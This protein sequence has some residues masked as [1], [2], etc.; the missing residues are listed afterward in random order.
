MKNLFSK[1]GIIILGAI[2]VAGFLIIKP[3]NPVYE[4]PKA[5]AA[6]TCAGAD[7]M[8]VL[9][10]SN[11]MD[12]T[13]I[14]DAKSAARKFAEIALSQ[15]LKNRV[16]V[17]WFDSS[18]PEE[19][20]QDL[21]SVLSQV[22][23]A[24]DS[25]NASGGT[26]IHEGMKRARKHL[27]ADNIE[28]ST[29]IMVILTDGVSDKNLADE[30]AN[31]FDG[32]TKEIFS[33]LLTS[34]LKPGDL[35]KAREL[36]RSIA[37]HP[38]PAHYFESPQ[39]EDL[40][41]IFSSIAEG[42]PT[43]DRDGDGFITAECKDLCEASGGCD[44]DDNNKCIAP[45]AP[46]GRCVVSA[47]ACA[48]LWSATSTKAAYEKALKEC[49]DFG[50]DICRLYKE[51]N[52]SDF[53]TDPKCGYEEN[54]AGSG[55]Y[56]AGCSD[57]FDNNQNGNVDTAELTCPKPGG[58][59]VC[60]RYA[61]DPTT[62]GID[63]SEPCGFC[64][65]FSLF[66]RIIDW[67]VLKIAPTIAALLLIIGGLAVATSRGNQ[68][69]LTRGKDTIIWTLAGYAVILVGWML[70][71]SFFGGI[72]V[73]TWTGIG[74]ESGTITGI[75]RAADKSGDTLF[76]KEAAW[77]DDEFNG[78]LITI[79]KDPNHPELEGQSR[80]ILDTFKD[81]VGGRLHTE[82]WGDVVAPDGDE[83]FRIGGDWWQ[84]TCGTE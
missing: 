46:E 33:V 40:K 74:G 7:I 71:N 70:V 47:E 53:Y 45:R 3:Q 9:D 11:S 54:P 82:Y 64:H 4:V 57:G 68:A 1:S 12:G 42:L 15:Q 2:L 65:F 63:E 25:G 20:A 41:N 31:A 58:L 16:G 79:T 34:N 37:S 67:V 8:L 30:E 81:A 19:L 43:L 59:T 69:Q 36:M 61:D 77:E 52:V 55:T 56:Y 17:V 10:E 44:A 32:A 18:S 29:E 73:K 39:P 51:K 14:D 49:A 28:S 21:T 78:M 5:H 75:T 60:G 38:K 72:G 27:E 83:S 23:S 22:N 62:L 76:T 50:N 13:P 48:T 6:K 84:S 80:K 26:K 35:T 66:D 24:I